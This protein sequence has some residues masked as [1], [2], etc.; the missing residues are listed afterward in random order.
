LDFSDA[1]LFAAQSGHERISDTVVTIRKEIEKA[2]DGE[3]NE[4]VAE[5]LEELKAK[6]QGAMNDDLNTAVALSVI[7][8][9]V[10]LAGKLYSDG[11]ATRSTFEKVNEFLTRLGGDV[12]GIVKDK[13]PA[14]NSED[15][16]I[17]ADINLLANMRE[18]ARQNKSF[19]LADHIRQYLSASGILIKD[20][21]EGYFLE[22]AERGV[23]RYEYLQKHNKWD[24]ASKAKDGII[25]AFKKRY[26][27]E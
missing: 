23:S 7:F 10:R 20:T 17:L 3:L 18:V 21:P 4:K 6:F 16:E 2:G 25:D 27:A 19:V 26:K 14:G 1:A 8:D 11:T 24:E 9:I 12:L 5:Q 15:R 13:Y 22:E